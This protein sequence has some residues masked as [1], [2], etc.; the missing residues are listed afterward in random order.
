MRL[1]EPIT[2]DLCNAYPLAMM[3]AQQGNIGRG[4]IVTLTFGG[5]IINPTD[6][7]VR[8]WAKKPDGTASY[9][10]CEVVEGKV[11][12]DFTNQMLA[13]QGELQ[14][15]LQLLSEDTDITTPIFIVNVG[16][17]NIDPNGTISKNEN[18]I[19]EELIANVETL[20]NNSPIY[21]KWNGDI[22]DKETIT[23]Q[24]TTF[25]KVSNLTYTVDELD[26]SNV[27]INGFGE[28]A[29][30]WV[31]DKSLFEETDDMIILKAD[32][33][34]ATV[35]FG[36]VVK[37]DIEGSTKGIYFMDGSMANT[38]I[39][40]EKLSEITPNGGVTSWNDLT[41]K[42]FYDESTVLYE[43]DGNTEGLESVTDEYGMTSYK[44]SDTPLTLEQIVGSEFEMVVGGEI[45]AG[46]I[47]DDMQ[48][49]I[50]AEDGSYIVFLLLTSVLVE[51][52]IDGATYS[53]GTW[54]STIDGMYVSSL[55]KDVVKQLDPKFVDGYTKEQIDTMFGNYV[56][57]VAELVGGE[58]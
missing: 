45:N 26:G 11:K 15:E 46:V 44:I 19:L 7:T 47:T 20:T 1:Y 5:A 56:T 40:T 49:L 30:T 17:S 22:T 54:A 16:K 23:I 51:K 31:V 52:E 10:K 24:N 28:D 8:V 25:Y 50:V 55:S 38:R 36:V 53:V 58:A 18:M 39:F 9:I 48:E 3:C 13:S 6:E 33:G 14:V 29:I 41:D 4:A 34:S 27:E 12:I 2:V 35:T 42:P 32:G 21:I 43:W 57:E 37:H